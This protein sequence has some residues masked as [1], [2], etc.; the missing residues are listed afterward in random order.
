MGA[1]L[2]LWRAQAGSHVH[3]DD[4]LSLP[5]PP[6]RRVWCTAHA[7]A[8]SRW[9]HH[10]AGSSAASAPVTSWLAGPIRAARPL[11]AQLRGLHA[12]AAGHSRRHLAQCSAMSPIHTSARMPQYSPCAGV[13]RR[14]LGWLLPVRTFRYCTR[15]NVLDHR[16]GHAAPLGPARDLAQ[17]RRR[18]FLPL[19][20][21][22]VVSTVSKVIRASSRGTT[23]D[24][25][26]VY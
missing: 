13:G 26:L 16:N 23:Y 25:A 4:R 15:V 22:N 9:L 6:S 5:Q 11:G 12:E 18:F 8:S 20:R 10:S 1:H 21:Q 17:L 3:T 19:L 2:S 24:G 14:F 7:P